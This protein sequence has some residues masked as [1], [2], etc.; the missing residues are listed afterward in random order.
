MWQGCGDDPQRVVNSHPAR[1]LS[2]PA[3]ASEE[4]AMARKPSDFDAD[5]QALMD[6]A[7]KVKSQKTLTGTR[8]LD[9]PDGPSTQ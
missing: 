1:L 5:L 3:A 2:R 9:G 7:K 8:V 4:L 6:K